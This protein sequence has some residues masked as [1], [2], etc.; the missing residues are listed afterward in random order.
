MGWLSNRMM[1]G[2]SNRVM[3]R[4]ASEY[5]PGP[6]SGTLALALGYACYP[7]ATYGDKAEH[8]AIIKQI[9][10]SDLTPCDAKSACS[11]VEQWL[12]HGTLTTDAVFT[13][14]WSMGPGEFLSA[15]FGDASED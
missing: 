11:A 3:Q 10:A 4:L 6:A 9:A 15:L 7:T 12:D 2:A 5:G 8:D 14:I 1:R 13:R